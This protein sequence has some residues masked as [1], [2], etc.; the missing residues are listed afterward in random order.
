MLWLTEAATP[1]HKLASA[2]RMQISRHVDTG[3]LTG[4]VCCQIVRLCQLQP[5][6]IV[7]EWNTI[8]Q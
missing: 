4:V 3:S 8:L 7:N 5:C 2:D 1:G 6:Q